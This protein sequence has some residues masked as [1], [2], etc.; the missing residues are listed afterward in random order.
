MPLCFLVAPDRWARYAAVCVFTQGHPVGA[1]VP[2]CYAHP[3]EATGQ[4]CDGE[5]KVDTERGRCGIG[6][7]FPIA[8]CANVPA[9]GCAFFF[10]ALLLLL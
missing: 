10:I 8:P 1:E 3:E 2:D 6:S 9:P 5:T 7:G 4:N